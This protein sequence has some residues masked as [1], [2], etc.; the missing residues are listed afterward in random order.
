MDSINNKHAVEAQIYF[1]VIPEWVLDLPITASA[2]R[3]YCCLRRYADNR[4]G[5]CW[6]SRR[7]LAMRSRVS[8]ATLDRSLRELV[9]QG[10]IRQTRRKNNAGDWT[11]NLYT[12]L[13]LPYGV[14]SK[15]IP[16]TSK[17]TATGQR[18]YVAQT[19]SNVNDKHEQRVYDL[20]PTEV[21]LPPTKEQM[22]KDAIEFRVLAE[23]GTKKMRP[24]MLRL[25]E[26]CELTAKELE[27]DT[28]SNLPTV[29]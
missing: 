28:Q 12:V 10:A 25:A 5:E 6:P 24:M 29:D 4:T 8:V 15:L 14:A 18:K 9:E 19:R 11:S 7:T 20:I 1:A 16:P 17:I 23:T 13:A 22:L 21:A 3:V 27:H 26:K 2:V